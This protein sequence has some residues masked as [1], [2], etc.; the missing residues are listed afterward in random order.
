MES[1]CLK[2]EKNTGN[3]DSEISSTSNGRV[4]ILSNFPIHG[5]KNRDLLKIKTQKDYQVS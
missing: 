2:C 4:M 5:R 1:Y 3:I